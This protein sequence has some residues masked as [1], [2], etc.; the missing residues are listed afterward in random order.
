MSLVQ[1]IFE[2]PKTE[3]KWRQ[4]FLL[5][6]F[7]FKHT[8]YIKIYKIK[9]KKVAEFNFK[10][11]H[12]ILPCRH[13]LNM[14]KL[15]NNER[16]YFCDNIETVEH[17]LFY[18]KNVKHIWHLFL[19]QNNTPFDIP[20]LIL[21]KMDFTFDWAVSLIQ[22]IIFKNWVMIQNNKGFR[23]I[24]DFLRKELYYRLSVYHYNG[25]S[26]LVNVLWRFYISL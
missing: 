2:K 9:D 13:N 16:C 4:Q 6:N 19:S 25:Y 3:N 11:L 15:V 12:K 24:L 20:L 22:Y 10:L 5:N 18:C 7:D 21:G 14:W 26:S 1:G 8:Y 17:M 23:N